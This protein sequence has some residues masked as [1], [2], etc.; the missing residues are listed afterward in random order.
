MPSKA[1]LDQVQMRIA[2]SDSVEEARKYLVTEGWE[3]AD[4]DVA[5]AEVTG[6]PLPKPKKAPFP[7][8]DIVGTVKKKLKQSPKMKDIPKSIP[9]VTIPKAIDKKPLITII[10]LILLYPVGVVLTWAWTPWNRVVKM[11]LTVPLVLAVIG[12]VVFFAPGI[13]ITSDT[14]NTVHRDTTGDANGASGG[15]G[16]AEVGEKCFSKSDCASGICV[17]V[18]GQRLCSSGNAGDNC[19]LQLDCNESLSCVDSRCR[20]RS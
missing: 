8:K 11:L 14:D 12:A 16:S 1:L 20:L 10:T 13:F 15:A 5:L 6:T 18:E 9:P 7:K 17:R 3:E 4:I 2:Q 19:N